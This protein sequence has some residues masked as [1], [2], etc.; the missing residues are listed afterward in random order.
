MQRS[1][2]WSPS[3]LRRAQRH[4]WLWHDNSVS[5][6]VNHKHRQRGC[7]GKCVKGPQLTHYSK[8]NWNLAAVPLAFGSVP[9]EIGLWCL[10][11]E[12]GRTFSC[13][14]QGLMDEGSRLC[15][16]Q[17]FQNKLKKWNSV[18]LHACCM[19]T[20]PANNCHKSQEG[21]MSQL[22]DDCALLIALK[23][24]SLNLSK[25]FISKKKW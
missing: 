10:G 16:G 18:L 23:K 25:A 13:T 11:E 5:L 21:L 24:K 8:K 17:C 9:S 1:C 3:P 20:Q 22:T 7:F 14:A 12:A 6:D 15:A 19:P 4:K 2:W